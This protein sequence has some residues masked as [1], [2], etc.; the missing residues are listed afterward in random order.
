MK[1]KLLTVLMISVV[2]IGLSAQTHLGIK[3]GLGISSY[4]GS[5]WDTYKDNTGYGTEASLTASAGIFLNIKLSD[6]LS[7]QPEAAVMSRS[8]QY[9]D[10]N[11]YTLDKYTLIELPV[12]LKYRANPNQGV[13]SFYFMG[14]PEL[15]YLFGDFE[16]ESSFSLNFSESVDDRMDTLFLTGVAVG[17]GYEKPTAAGVWSYCM[18]YSRSLTKMIESKEIFFQGLVFEIGYQ[19]GR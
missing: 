7:I 14:G 8:V 1:K 2:I 11:D 5:D 17:I 18:K 6:S 15:N 9:G 16:Q 4:A 3:G 19:F 10:V 13:G 12:Y